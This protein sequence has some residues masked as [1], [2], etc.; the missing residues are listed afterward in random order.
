MASR[1]AHPLA[2]HEST[3]EARYIVCSR[4]GEFSRTVELMKSAV[5]GEPLSPADFTLSVHHALAGLLSIACKNMA[6][7]T[8]IAAGCDT[9]GCGMLEAVG[10]L[11]T[12]PKRPVLLVY[13]DAALPGAYAELDNFSGE[14]EIALALLL[15]S[16]VGEGDLML[17]VTP[18]A[19]R[20]RGAAT[21]QAKQ[22]LWFLLTR[23]G[24]MVSPGERMDW[25]WRRAA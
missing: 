1:V 9:F 8:A 5:A 6:G 16:G 23:E 17:S 7:H 25:H 3:C 19:A 12:Q 2:L 22:F 14:G 18:A 11:T 4:H 20:I 21:E 10:C 15:S 24:E 13:Y